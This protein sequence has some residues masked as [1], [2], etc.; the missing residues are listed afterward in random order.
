MATLSNDDAT[1]LAQRLRRRHAQ[2]R[3][4]LE[5]ALTDSQRKNFSEIGGPVRDPGDESVANL[6]TTTNIA[7]ARRDGDELRDVEA[8][9]ARV[10]AGSYGVCVECGRDIERE[11]LAA[12]PTATRCIDDQR[13]HERNY[14]GGRD[15]SP[16]L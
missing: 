5:G 12:N 14:A 3:A 9:L 1:E 11:R 13:R 2:L 4:R 10:H 16:S 6:E 8:A 15:V 7:S